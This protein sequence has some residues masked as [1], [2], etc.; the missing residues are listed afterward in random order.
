[1]RANLRRKPRIGLALGGG[2]ARGWAHI[3]VIRALQ[4]RDIHPDFV[5][6]TSIGALVGSVYAAGKLDEFEQWL[7]KLDIRSI[8]SLLDLHLNGG[9]L[10]GDKLMD[11]YRKEYGNT[12]IE[13]LQMPFAAVATEL[14]N[15]GE[16]WLRH[17]STA[18]AVR[19][20]IAVPGMFS[21]V[22]IDDQLLVD[23]GLVNP[24]PVSLARAMGAD[25]VI[26]VDLNADNFNRH[27]REDIPPEQ[28]E[29]QYLN[30]KQ[31]IQDAFLGLFP[32]FAQEQE[33]KLP[34]VV[35]VLAATIT[36]MQVRITRSRL[37]GDPPDLLVLP[38]MSHVGLMEFHRTREGLDEGRRAVELL[39]PNM[40]ALGLMT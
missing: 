10:R 12:Q 8:V 33:Q 14:H 7:M 2:A 9:V 15:G 17:G 25:L 38:Q 23:G 6:G 18:D 19:A 30:W 26:A 1:M 39:E 20:S 27:L 35:D 11:F 13:N 22:W 21:P 37:A 40:R 32:S 28:S 31:R 16:V 5:C 3:G 24:V 29:P 34:S 4:E 36:I